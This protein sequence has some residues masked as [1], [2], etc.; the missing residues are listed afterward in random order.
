MGLAVGG[1]FLSSALNVFFD[2]M[3]PKFPDLFRGRK[4]DEQVL[5][6]LKRSLRAIEAVVDDAD[7][8]Q[9]T[10]WHVSEWLS[11]LKATLYEAEDLVEEKHFSL[12]A[13]SSLSLAWPSGIG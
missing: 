8:K 11:E 1:A 6:K 4:G 5:K 7:D 10:N 13:L 3:T 2:R 12:K 9:T